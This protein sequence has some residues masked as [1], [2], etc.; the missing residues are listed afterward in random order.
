MWVEMKSKSRVYLKQPLALEDTIEL[1]EHHANYLTRVLRLKIGDSFLVFN[2]QQGEYWA[3]VIEVSK[4]ACSIEVD[5]L[6]RPAIAEPKLT[7]LFAPIKNPN[8]HYYVQKATE[9]GVTDLVPIITARTIVR[10]VNVEKLSVV[11]VEA[12]EQSERFCPPTIHPAQQIADFMKAASQYTR[13][14]FCDERGSAKTLIEAATEIG[15]NDAI[16]IGP[17]GGFT[18]DERDM[19]LALPNIVPVSLSSN[20]LRA[21]TAMILALGAYQMVRNT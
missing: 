11:A 17:E 10:T 21:E 8:T 15:S 2:G 14:I 5:S 7:L 3:K 12:V 19:L 18:A 1:S 16:L 4:R 6:S 20:I 13:I 9:L